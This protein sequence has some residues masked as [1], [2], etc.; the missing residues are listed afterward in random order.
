M[1]ER[2]KAPTGELVI[3]YVTAFLLFPVGLLIGI[4]VR[5]RDTKNGIRLI[6]VSCAI[7]VASI[8]FGVM[9]SGTALM[10]SA[11]VIAVALGISFLA[12]GRREGG[13]GGS[14]LIGAALLFALLVLFGNGGNH[15]GP[16][17]DEQIV[18]SAQRTGEKMAQCV[19]SHPHRF[20]DCERRV[21][22]GK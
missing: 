1:V 8:L 22:L 21:L 12:D 11:A 14:L 10:L 4:H 15:G 16:S 5:A 20:K 3:G 13:I 7:G 17:R 2:E 18:H 19:T 6:A 9:G